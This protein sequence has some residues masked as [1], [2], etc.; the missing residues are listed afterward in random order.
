MHNLFSISN[1]FWYEFDSFFRWEERRCSRE[2]DR[3]IRCFD[4]LSCH[5][6]EAK[7]RMQTVSKIATLLATESVNSAPFKREERGANFWQR[8]VQN[9]SPILTSIFFARKSAKLTTNFSASKVTSLPSV[10]LSLT[11]Y[12]S[13]SL[14]LSPS[15][16]HPQYRKR[17]RASYNKW[18][19]IT[20]IT[21]N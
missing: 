15:A 9:S 3:L 13:L 10:F 1:S 14:S 6:T 5:L 19:S 16:P 2:F 18:K 8:K 11:L 21:H 7:R 4:P 17:F 12:L 20:L